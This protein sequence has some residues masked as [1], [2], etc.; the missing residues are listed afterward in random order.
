MSESD[1]DVIPKHNDANTRLT[2]DHND[3]SKEQKP[4]PSGPREPR[5][6]RKMYTCKLCQAQFSTV[7]NYK[8]HLSKKVSCFPQSD[9]QIFKKLIDD[10]IEALRVDDETSMIKLGRQMARLYKVLSDEEKGDIDEDYHEGVLAVLEDI[11]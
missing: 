11:Q 2:Q 4:L 10:F 3:D 9:L 8:R 6:L 5:V 7:E 1:T